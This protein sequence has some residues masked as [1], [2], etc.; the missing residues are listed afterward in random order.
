ME[1]DKMV[2][3]ET[4]DDLNKIINQIHREIW[5]KCCEDLEAHKL[6]HAMG[7]RCP[8]NIQP[9]RATNALTEM[10]AKAEGKNIWN[11]KPK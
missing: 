4:L 6:Y 5:K 7:V 8:C 1:D 11:W 3:N 9:E 2:I 10:E